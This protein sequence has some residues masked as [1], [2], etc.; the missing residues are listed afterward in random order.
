MNKLEELEKEIRKELPELMEVSRGCII[1]DEYYGLCTV[2]N[3][4]NTHDLVYQTY[5]YDHDKG[6]PKVIDFN[7]K[8]LD[9]IIGHPIQLHHVL[10]WLKCIEHDLNV[11]ELNIKL[12]GQFFWTMV[13]N[14]YEIINTI[15]FWDFDKLLKDQSEDLI[16]YLHRLINK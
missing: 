9:K 10:K 11:F 5:C 1:N 13:E 12:T 2:I 7:K 3:A 8:D 4:D 6:L 14:P 15:I 16:D